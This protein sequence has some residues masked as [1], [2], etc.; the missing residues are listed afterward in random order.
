MTLSLSST[1]KMQQQQLPRILIVDH[2]DS[3][4]LNLLSLLASIAASDA[5]LADRVVVLPHTHHLLVDQQ[6]FQE[7]VLPHFDA[8]ILSPGPGSPDKRH[9][10]GFGLDYLRDAATHKM[11]TLG[12]CLGHQGLAVAF[13]GR[14]RRAKSIQHGTAS[15]LQY[16]AGEVG[17]DLFAG[18][19]RGTAVTR[20]NSL[21]VEWE[22]LPDCL[23]ITAFADDPENRIARPATSDL[24][25]SRAASPSMVASERCILGL[26]HKTLPLWGCQFHPES[27]ESHGGEQLMRNFLEMAT[28]A[29]H[30]R[31]I[32]SSSCPTIPVS[33]RGQGQ[34]YVAAATGQIDEPLKQAIKPVSRRFKVV[35]HR[36]P[37]S[38]EATRGQ[39]AVV[40]DRLFR[41][42]GERGAIWLDSAREGDPQSN[43]SYMTRA[44]FS[45]SYRRQGKQAAQLSI[46]DEE[47]Q[48]WTEEAM[49]PHTTFWQYMNEL[50]REFQQEVAISADE[51]GSNRFRTGFVGYWGYEM[52][53]ESLDLQ[54]DETIS[55]S[56][57]G[58][59]PD[60]EFAMCEAVLELDHRKK[61]WIAS[62]LVRL[63]GSGPPL[64]EDSRLRGIETRRKGRQLGMSETEAQDWLL[65]VEAVLADVAASRSPLEGPLALPKLEPL[66]GSFD[67]QAKVEAARALIAQG[68]SYELCLT[69]QFVGKLPAELSRDH[70]CIYQSLRR[71]NPAPYAAY[72]E[73]PTLTGSGRARSILSTSPERF[74]SKTARGSVEMKPIKGT[75]S[76]AG[77]AN[78]AERKRLLSKIDG[79]LWAAREDKRRRAI[80]SADPKERAENLMIV[81]LIRAD[82]LSF[83]IPSTVKVPLLMK[84]ETYES[85]H[86]LVTTVQGQAQPG[87]GPVEALRRCFP[88]GSMTG[89]PKR[90]SVTLLER[91]EGK[92]RAH[93]EA[94][95]NTDD[96]LLTSEVSAASPSP[97][98]LKHRPRGPYSG[99]L[100]WIGV[101]GATD[102]SVVIRTAVIE[103]DDITVGAGGAITYLSDAEKEWEEVLHK[104][105]ALGVY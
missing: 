6:A 4:T 43:R 27:I 15:K 52:K 105:K 2:F 69:T 39:E 100:G 33:I 22:E 76:R 68:E 93:S 3:Y 79:P 88:P 26:A 86:Q 81:D 10:F 28:R 78:A 65:Q 49:P 54:S 35:Q 36:L 63:T 25:Q 83:C 34:R 103:G 82:L 91:L 58:Q 80:L 70:F 45:I 13:G 56:S 23:E 18:I 37:I 29:G 64:R 12:V 47:T 74:L 16:P 30:E 90:R 8:V 89:A 67:Y 21:T 59:S 32:P 60:A 84:V 77:Y 57:E 20:Y 9:D 104:V 101:D 14:V 55:L 61:E 40:F 62:V 96:N 42:E 85:V 95:R 7:H 38:T 46:F 97:W 51:S 71:M 53:S 17:T 75:L 94:T 66:D 44:T 48:A 92:S 99:A 5:E 98:Q 87:V 19:K 24:M 1:D 31:Q 102:F 50:Q 72:L 11:P 41:R 73:L